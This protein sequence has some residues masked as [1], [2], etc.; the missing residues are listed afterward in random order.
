MKR[1]FCYLCACALF[2]G[3]FVDSAAAQCAAGGRQGSAGGSG[4][5]G[6]GMGRGPGTGRQGGGGNSQMAMLA[7]LGRSR[8]MM[9]QQGGMMGRQGGMMQQQGGM[10]GQGMMIQ[11]QM[12]N[13]QQ[14]R[15][16]AQQFALAAMR[17]DRDGSGTLDRSELTQVAHTVL[18]EMRQRQ[19]LIPGVMP[20]RY[21]PER[22]SQPVSGRVTQPI[23]N[24]TLAEAFV[25]RSLTFDKDDDGH[26]NLAETRAMAAA[27]V[28]SL[29]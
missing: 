5:G 3:V 27:F 16:T 12:Q 13:M 17:M 19:M 9:Q 28:S 29:G 6:S 7:M 25:R 26:L 10:M 23:N 24:T 11:R 14:Q 4:F 22:A 1:S 15:P 20:V 2:S 8:G 21:A 18:A